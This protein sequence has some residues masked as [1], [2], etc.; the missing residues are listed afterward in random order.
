MKD[1]TMNTIQ[2][3]AQTIETAQ[4]AQTITEAAAAVRGVRPVLEC[5]TVGEYFAR[6]DAGEVVNP[7]Y[8][9]GLRWPVKMLDAFA[10]DAIA[11]KALPPLI[12]SAIPCADGVLYIRTDGNQRTFAL[13]RARDALA[14]RMNEDTPTEEGGKAEAQLAALESALLPILTYQMD[15]AAAADFFK[16]LN[17]GVKLSGVQAA[18][19][20]YTTS[21]QEALNGLR[22]R[23]EAQRGAATRWG[24]ANPDTAS[25]MLLAAVLNPGKASSASATARLVL[26]ECQQPG[27]DALAACSTALKVLARLEA[28][29]KAISAAIAKE[30]AAAAA[31]DAAGEVYIPGEGASFG[32]D[33]PDGAYWASPARLVPLALLCQQAQKGVPAEDMPALVTRLANTCRTI[34]R[35]A[36]GKISITRPARGKAP[37]KKEAV[38]VCD[39]WSDTSNAHKATSARFQHLRSYYADMVRAEQAK[40]AQ[41]TSAQTAQPASVKD[42]AAAFTAA[43]NE[44]GVD[45][46]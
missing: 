21:V 31:A 33:G 20:E 11:G 5:I 22:E 37:A 44:G 13:S 42:A 41:T 35:H 38:A 36:K 1:A 7:A 28:S 16:R 12:L 39:I 26:K 19:A 30:E 17:A 46:D 43:V 9:S 29:D 10:A 25:S 23:M 32:P 15:A 3:A 40:A 6:L 45:N 8:Q 27:A 14:E 4:N 34:N 18:K 2:T 24:K